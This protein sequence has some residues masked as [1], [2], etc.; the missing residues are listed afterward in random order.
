MLIWWQYTITLLG[1]LF[2]A[3]LSVWFSQ[4]LSN[5]REYMKSLKN[6]RSE[7]F[8]NIYNADLINKWIDKNINA[9][10]DNQVLV[11]T[12]PHLYNFAWISVR[13]A[14]SYKDFDIAIKL[15]NAYGFLS[16]INDVMSAIEE[17]KWGA[18]SAMTGSQERKIK[19]FEVM[20]ETINTGLIPHLKEVLVLLDKKIK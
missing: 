3:L 19:L 7:V 9:L 17:L 10:K 6:L 20:R 1:S 15:E 2:V 13:G 14:V 4:W 11:A 18:G 8:A 16:S 5:R 12:C